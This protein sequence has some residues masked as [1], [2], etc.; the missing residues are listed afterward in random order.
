M[1]K[2]L[3]LILFFCLGIHLVFPQT[4]DTLRT[5]D[6]IQRV[7]D[8]EVKNRIFYKRL[9]D[10]LQQHKVTERLK[11]FI[12]VKE[13]HSLAEVSS[14][15][16]DTIK[17][18]AEPVCDTLSYQG[19]IIRN[20]LITTLDPFGF[21]ERD[22]NK[23]PISKF[24][25]YGNALHIKTREST[26][27]HLL[28]FKK[29]QALDTLLISETERLLRNQRY[30]RRVYIEPMPVGRFKDSVDLHIRVLD[31]W[32][33]YVDGDLTGSRGWT[34]LSERNLFG[35]GHEASFTYQQ[36]FTGIA[37]SGKG[38]SYTLR[39]I[40]NT[41]VNV[42]G[43]YY[44]DYEGYFTRYIYVDRQLYS[45][46]ARWS[47][48]VS[49]YENR[50]AYV[51]TIPNYKPVLY[52]KSF[53]TFGSWVKPLGV[54]KD[55]S[56]NNFIIG[57]TYRNTS[58]YRN[59]FLYPKEDVYHSNENI[60]L[61]QL[62]LNR[63]KFVKDR[64]IFRNGDTEDVGTGHTLYLTS[65]AI[66]KN[67]RMLPYISLGFSKAY[68]ERKGY[69]AAD[70][71]VGSFFPKGKIKELVFRAEGIHFTKLL[72]IGDWHFREFLKASFVMGVKDFVYQGSRLSINEHY[73]IL[74]FNSSE[75]YGNR[76][77]ILSSQT[78]LYSP[79][80]FIGFRVS[81]FLSVDT[82][83]IGRKESPFFNVDLYSRFSLGFYITNDY[84]PFGAIQFSL[85]YFPIIPG[86]GKHIFKI[87]GDTN[88]DFRLHS[89]SQRVPSVISFK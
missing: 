8:R 42:R 53:N 40:R 66:W 38:M 59:S 85:A 41:Y 28:L 10:Y 20:I 49:Y 88:D 74:G 71:E 50:D 62:S 7:L 73:G 9:R 37:D 29:N 15:E 65:G 26:I 84:L 21:D 87:T 34:R 70:F 79:F 5:S 75:V 43:S 2:E 51:D 17:T 25:R 58:F 64:Y 76:K 45:P 46:L 57:A 48:S 63:S 31:S 67:H 16:K 22:T 36:F 60:F 86:N 89:F 13:Q 33:M 54:S 27:R 39:N 1:M 14:T 61:T 55:K 23:K 77:L 30:V 80:Q 47:G 78:Q 35:L 11:D 3:A 72:S 82:A 32:T 81:P 18:V 19:K 6:T 56:I 44:S 4:E 69:Y 83:F 12:V 52:Y 24:E 68:Y